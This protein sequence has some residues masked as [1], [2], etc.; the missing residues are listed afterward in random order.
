VT[1]VKASRHDNALESI[2]NDSAN[3]V[4]GGDEYS[5]YQATTR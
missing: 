5:R 2:V 3:T 1:T 4:L